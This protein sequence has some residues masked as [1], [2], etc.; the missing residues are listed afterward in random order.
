MDDD[1]WLLPL[2]VLAVAVALIPA[3]FG[4]D[5]W[6]FLVVTAGAVLIWWESRGRGGAE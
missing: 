6:P 1:P 3:A 2:T 4:G 5:W